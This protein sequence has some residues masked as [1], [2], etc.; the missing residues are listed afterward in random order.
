LAV[1]AE[2]DADLS[3]LRHQIAGHALTRFR[4]ALEL[5]NLPTTIQFRLA[6]Q[7]VRAY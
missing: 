3:A 1:T 4:Q 7:R 5:G 6:A 2:P